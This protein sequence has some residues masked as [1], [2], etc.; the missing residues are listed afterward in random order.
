M[1][2]YFSISFSVFLLESMQHGKHIL[3]SLNLIC[4]LHLQDDEWG[5]VKIK[6][7]SVITNGVF[8]T[9]HWNIYRDAPS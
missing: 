6:D 1:I 5:K 2:G 9:Y 8:V 3:N 7:V 4:S